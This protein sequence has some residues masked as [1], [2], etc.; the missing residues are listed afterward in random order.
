MDAGRSDPTREAAAVREVACHKPL[1]WQNF[2]APAP[3]EEPY[4]PG[5]HAGGGSGWERLFN[6]FRRGS[7]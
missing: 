6:R 4:H 7:W 3:V 1:P 2:M 5:M